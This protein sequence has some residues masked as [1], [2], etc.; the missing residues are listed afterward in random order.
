MKRIENETMRRS[1]LAWV[2]EENSYHFGGE[3]NWVRAVG[4][5]CAELGELVDHMLG[6]PV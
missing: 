4:G 5:A 6:G 2:A 3:E 1:S